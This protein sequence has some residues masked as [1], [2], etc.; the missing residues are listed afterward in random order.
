MAEL[1]NPTV[2]GEPAAPSQPGPWSSRQ[3]DR[4]GRGRGEQLPAGGLGCPPPTVLPL[5]AGQRVSCHH[6]LSER[7][8]AVALPQ[9]GAGNTG[10]SSSRR[11]PPSPPRAPASTAASPPAPATA[12]R[13][14]R[15][16]PSDPRAGQLALDAPS[17]QSGTHRHR[18]LIRGLGSKPWRCT[19]PDLVFPVPASACLA[20][21]GRWLAVAW[22]ARSACDGSA[23]RLLA[24]GRRG[25]LGAGRRGPRVPGTE[26]AAAAAVLATVGLRLWQAKTLITHIDEG[27]DLLGWRIHRHRK[28]GPDKSYVCTYP[29]KK[30]VKAVTGKVRALSRLNRNQPLDVLLHNLNPVLRGWCTHFQPGLSSWPLGSAPV[31]VP[32][33]GRACAPTACR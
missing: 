7:D 13:P 16:G 28:P 33:Y 22:A 11:W 21:Y 15:G 2:G 10:P 12:A 4:C 25:R 14:G 6:H 9:N 20:W 8:G 1:C 17:A 5:P 27:L 26:A 29:S 18:S 31:C 23:C 30:A 19:R 24:T 32:C 3:L